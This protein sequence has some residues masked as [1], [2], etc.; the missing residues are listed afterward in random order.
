MTPLIVF[1]VLGSALLHA[2]WNSLA[3][4]VPDR[5]VCIS[6]IGLVDAIGG[7]VMIAFAGLPPAGAWP[8]IIASAVLHVAY[9]LLLAASYELGE[10]SQMYP[11][12]RGTSPWVVALV[13]VFLLG[14]PLPPAELLGVLAVSGGLLGLVLVGGL[15][16]RKQLPALGVATLTGLMI[17]GYTVVDG[18]G[19]NQAPLLAYSGWMFLLEGLPMPLIALARRRGDVL[20]DSLRACAVPGLV[21]GVVAL[22]AY[23]IV[24]WA[25]TS[26]ALAPVA[27]LRETSIVFGALIGSLFLGERL[28]HRRAVAAAVVLAGVLLISLP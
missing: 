5:L 26:G 6:L 12:A 16:G 17:A 10:F 11:L 18:L 25:Q 19:V 24:L 1:A 13:S 20:A 28:G 15:P 9:A 22:A 2:T 23:T 21:G 7:A 27:A 8:F 4:A 14:H 3:H